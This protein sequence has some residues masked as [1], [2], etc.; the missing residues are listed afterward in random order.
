MFESGTSIKVTSMVLVYLVQKLP[1]TFPAQ[2]L[3]S[4]PKKIYRKAHDRNRVKRLMREGYRKNKGIHYAVLEEQNLQAAV[5][6]IFTGRTLPDA[7]Y[8]HGKIKE[9][10]LRFASVIS[11]TSSISH[12][13]D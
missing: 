5:L 3:I 4:V 10:L 8:V 13:K 11:K 12:A 7:P 6:I 1:T 2:V 9:L